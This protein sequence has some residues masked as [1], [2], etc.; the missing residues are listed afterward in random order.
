MIMMITVMVMKRVTLISTLFLGS[1]IILLIQYPLPEPS[2]EL[3]DFAAVKQRVGFDKFKYKD[4]K[5][6]LKPDCY[7]WRQCCGEIMISVEF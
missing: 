1:T 4:S 7:S 6:L 5:S 2:N 3:A